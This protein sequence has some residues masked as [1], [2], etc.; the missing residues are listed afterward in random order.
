MQ[1]AGMHCDTQPGFQNASHT[2]CQLHAKHLCHCSVMQHQIRGLGTHRG[3]TSAPAD[4]SASS[5]GNS[6]FLCRRAPS[7]FRYLLRSR[8]ASEVLAF[9]MSLGQQHILTDEASQIFYAGSQ[10]PEAAGRLT[11][12]A[13][14]N[15]EQ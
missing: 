8:T 3:L 2:S 14:D 6:P 11:V 5:P 9:G 12:T 15:G 10:A 4:S 13:H 1:S 7:C